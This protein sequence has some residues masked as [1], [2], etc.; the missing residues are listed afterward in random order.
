MFIGT[1]A[2][3]SGAVTR[4]E[5]ARWHRRIYPDVYC[6]KRTELSLKDRIYGA[7]LWSGRR[8]V[9][10]GLSAAAMQGA[11]W[12]DDDI[13]IE[14]IWNNSHAPEG[15]VVRND[16]LAADEVERF[17]RLPVTTCARTAF[18]LGRRLQRDAA[19]A[20]LDALMWARRFAVGDV[21]ALA[22]RYP[23]ARG[24]KALRMAMPLVDGG[25]AS[26]RET[27]LRLLLTDN[28]YDNLITQ[29]PIFDRHGLIGVA[30]MGWPELKIAVEYDG[31]Y[32]RTD[33]RRYVMD[34][35]K[36]R[37]LEAL[38]W[39]VIRVIA[40][41]DVADVLA[42]VD[43]ARKLRHTELTQGVSRTFAA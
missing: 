34:Q 35:R 22:A 5:L 41:D 7:W 37:R 23:R 9:V 36:L 31:D 1:E 43:R 14:L 2:L 32:H 33:R 40:E 21:H 29:I 19:V 27:W 38:G 6:A 12:I 13:P 4:H 25:A 24:L 18:D 26:P 8:A 42:R 16:T 3:A 28:G 20:R 30:D 39:I 10:A 15:L 17:G 11:P